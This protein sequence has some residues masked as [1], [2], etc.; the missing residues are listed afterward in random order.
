MGVLR[1]AVTA[2]LPPPHA[3]FA[4]ADPTEN[5]QRHCENYFLPLATC[6]ATTAVTAMF[7]HF[8][9]ATPLHSTPLLIT[10]VFLVK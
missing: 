10:S 5:T 1:V 4:T 7:C 3:R 2:S 8:L 6:T 9:D